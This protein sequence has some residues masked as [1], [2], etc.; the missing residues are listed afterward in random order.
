MRSIC[1]TL[2]DDARN[3][4]LTAAGTAEV[5]PALRHLIEVLDPPGHLTVTTEGQGLATGVPPALL[6][7]IVSPLLTNA[8]RYANSSVTVRAYRAADGVRVDVLD[9]GPAY[10]PGSPDSSSSPVNGRTRATDT[11]ELRP[12]AAG[13][14]ANPSGRRRLTCGPPAQG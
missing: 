8:C 4:A 9:D 11:A 2:L 3:G 6:E 10:R 13:L 7:H 5:L 12:G 1:D 14:A